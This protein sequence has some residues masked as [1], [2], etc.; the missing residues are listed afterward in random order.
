MTLKLRD[1]H[2]HHHHDLW[3]H[4]HAVPVALTITF[5]HL[6]L[7]FFSFPQPVTRVL[8]DANVNKATVDDIV[9]VGGST[10]IPKV[11]VDTHTHA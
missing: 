1:H 5:I 9:L 10:R 11:Q 6:L 2:H 3:S 7:L 4:A 8:K